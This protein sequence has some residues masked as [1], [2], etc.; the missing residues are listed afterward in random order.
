MSRL[1]R[2]MHSV[3]VSRVLGIFGWGV[4]VWCAHGKRNFRSKWLEYVEQMM[5]MMM[6]IVGVVCVF[7][8]DG[9]KNR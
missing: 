2:L 9:G 7:L 6:M 5:M 4:D 1:K 3:S 8:V